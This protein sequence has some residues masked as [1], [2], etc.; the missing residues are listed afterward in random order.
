MRRRAFAD[1]IPPLMRLRSHVNEIAKKLEINVIDTYQML[2][3]ELDKVSKETIWRGHYAPYGN[4]LVSKLVA[5][6]IAN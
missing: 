1:S 5:N 4:E 3:D 6:A 2:Q